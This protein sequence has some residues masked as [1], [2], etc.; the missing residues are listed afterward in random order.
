MNIEQILAHIET[1]LLKDISSMS[2]KDRSAFWANIKEF[3]TA[4]LQRQSYKQT[5][6][7]DTEF[8]I[9][10]INSKDELESNS[11]ISENNQQ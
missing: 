6:D 7:E 10:I 11:D 2:P 8:T 5:S 4:K 1:T 3:E 9:R